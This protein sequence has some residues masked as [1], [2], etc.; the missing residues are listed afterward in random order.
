MVGRYVHKFFFDT[1]LLD[2]M[3]GNDAEMSQRI[4]NEAKQLGIQ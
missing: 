2:Q 4:C 3:R 1:F